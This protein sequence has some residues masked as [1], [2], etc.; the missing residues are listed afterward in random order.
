[1][2]V[3]AC[4]GHRGGNGESHRAGNGIVA[5]WEI[6]PA[7]RVF[8]GNAEI[9]ARI[10]D[11]VPQLIW[12][13]TPNGLLEY[14]NSAW[15]SAVTAD[16]GMALETALLPR[17]HAADQEAWRQQWLAALR[18][19]ESYEFEYRLET[20]THDSR[21]WL[22]ER[23][24]PV[25]DATTGELQRWIMTGTPIDRYKR[26]EETLRLQLNQRDDFLATVLH[27]LRN[28]LT[29]IAGALER[30]RRSPNDAMS[31]GVARGII[32]RQL[33]Q[34]SCL[35]DDLLDVSRI[36][37]GGIRLQRRI[38]ELKDIVAVAVETAEPLIDVRQQEL[39]IGQAEQSVHLF[40]DPVRL[41]QVITNLL[42]NAAKFT[43]RGGHISILSGEKDGVVSI[44]VRDNGVG[45]PADKLPHIF[46]LYVQAHSGPTAGACG[47]G[48]GLA[49][50]RQMVELHGG[51]LS[52][53]SE[54][55]GRG[56]EFTVL[57]PGAH[58]PIGSLS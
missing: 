48:V 50:A 45:I 31:V 36:S 18:T 26:T 7:N 55:P 56:S 35:V 53:R 22:L 37:H 4:E 46:D 32:Q 54:G 33:R 20:L 10:M 14:G 52:V 30:L 13:T 11:S 42:M 29:P 51:T 21:R 49:V 15:K 16:C 3:T 40:A 5:H 8:R 41:T 44:R 38:V 27:E 12:S 25:R 34:L 43:H 6:P 1:M 23:G 57:L 2:T 28:P 39:T 17:L 19:G 9:L 24:T 47:L 58:R